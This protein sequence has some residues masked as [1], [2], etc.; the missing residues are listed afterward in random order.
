MRRR[1]GIEQDLA[2]TL[3]KRRAARFARQH[4]LEAA[5]FELFRKTAR[6]GRLARTLAA[7]ER[8]EFAS[9]HIV[10]W[11]SAARAYVFRRVSDPLGLTRMGTCR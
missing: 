1:I 5:S 10:G 7:F 6:L 11:V 8:D 9:C 3:G 4:N 2:H